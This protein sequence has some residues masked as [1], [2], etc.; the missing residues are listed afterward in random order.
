[1][2]GNP[3]CQ[4]LACLAGGAWLALPLG[5]MTNCVTSEMSSLVACSVSESSLGFA[6]GLDLNPQNAMRFTVRSNDR[7]LVLGTVIAL[8]VL[9][10][11]V[12]GTS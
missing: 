9:L 7:F 8:V 11:V 4:E 2:P 10:L 5:R 1:M 6:A 12:A 3:T